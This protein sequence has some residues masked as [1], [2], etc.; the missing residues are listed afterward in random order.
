MAATHR[1]DPGHQGQYRLGAGRP[2]PHRPGQHRDLTA[3]G[4][5]ARCDATARWRRARASAAAR[6]CRQ[7]APAPSQARRHR[8]HPCPGL[9]CRGRSAHGNGGRARRRP[10]PSDPRAAVTTGARG[11]ARSAHARG[12]RRG[13]RTRRAAARGESRG[14][15]RPGGAGGPVSLGGDGSCR[16][17]RAPGPALGGVPR[18]RCRGRRLALAEPARSHRLAGT[19]G[20]L[21]RRHR[22]TVPLPPASPSAYRAEAGRF[23][24]GRDRDARGGSFDPRSA[25]RQTGA[26]PCPAGAGGRVGRRDGAVARPRNERAS[27]RLPGAA[28]RAEAAGTGAPRGSRASADPAGPG[29]APA[30]GRRTRRGDTRGPVHHFSAGRPAAVAAGDA[31]R[32]DQRRKR[33]CARVRRCRAGAGFRA[34]RT[35]T[36]PP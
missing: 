24:L 8:I 26:R 4:L 35:S 3:R 36:H 21:A 28:R 32:A 20:D 15:E 34:P 18:W 14:N 25:S 13:A 7:P 1:C 11:C 5:A 22:P 33:G 17:V 27:G 10:V 2:A 9:D 16:H 31:A 29:L 6:G 23:R 12:C 19:R 30:R